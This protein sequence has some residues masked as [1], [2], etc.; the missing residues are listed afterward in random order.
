MFLDQKIVASFAYDEL[1]AR[2]ANVG[3]S[4]QIKRT[5]KSYAP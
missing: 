3:K 2:L 1:L 4:L 5:A